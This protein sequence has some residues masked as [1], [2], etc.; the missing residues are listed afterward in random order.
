MNRRCARTWLAAGLAAVAAAA[1]A[2]AGDAPVVTGG[3]RQDFRALPDGWKVQGKPRVPDAV[4]VI[5]E[6]EG[7]NRVLR[8]TAD[9][10]S[11]TFKSGALAVDLS[12]TPVVRWRWKALTLPGGADGRDP[13]RDD[14]AIG[15]YVSAGGMFSQKSVAFRWETETPKGAE[16]RAKYAAGVMDLSWRCVRNREDLGT[17][18]W[19][20]DE[21]NVA[22][23]FR[24]AFGSVPDRIGIGICCNSQ[25]TGTRA[26]ALL[27]WI[28]F[29]PA[30][31]PPSA[32]PKH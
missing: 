20:V 6:V 7:S 30:A 5:A 2:A 23:A 13:K 4:F 21:A 28:E 10:A 1:V 29:C 26:E 9:K 24:A 32:A 16:G 25:Y 31:S 27:D 22:D 12:R 19:Y 8:M 15:L 17:N 18:G 14:Q 11:A 3:W